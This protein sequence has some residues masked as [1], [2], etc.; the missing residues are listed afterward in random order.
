ME[1]KLADRHTG[2]KKEG[3]K[4]GREGEGARGG[5]VARNSNN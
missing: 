5:K 2:G 1:E 4:K 3:W